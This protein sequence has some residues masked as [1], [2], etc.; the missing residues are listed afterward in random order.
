MGKHCL[1]CVPAYFT[2]HIVTVWGLFVEIVVY[3]IS[4]SDLPLHLLWM[5]LVP[6]PLPHFPQSVSGV[7]AMELPIFKGCALRPHWRWFYMYIVGIGRAHSITWLWRFNKFLSHTTR[8][9]DHAAVVF[10][11]L[12]SRGKLQCMIYRQVTWHITHEFT[13]DSLLLHPHYNSVIM[14]HP[15]IL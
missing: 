14:F 11:I 13:P 4:F 2:C 7:D 5:F 3:L 6:P 15:C 1:A 8:R 9:A 10:W 12:L